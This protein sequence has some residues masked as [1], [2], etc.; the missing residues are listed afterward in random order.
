MSRTVQVSLPSEETD[1]VISK[2]KELKGLIGLRVQRNI[3]LQPKG[4]VVNVDL[5]NSEVNNFLFLLEQEGLLNHKYVSITTSKPT[6]VISES[7]SKKILAESHETSWE[8]M[9]KDLL[10]DSNMNFN[11]QLLML[12]SGF[13]AAVGISMSSVHIVVGAMLIAPGFEPLSRL[14]MGL[15]NKHKDWKNG[16]LDTLKGYFCLV[17]GSAAG[18][19]AVKLLAKD[20]L[21]G[22]SSYLPTGAL[23]EYWTSPTALSLSISVIA[24][25][26]GGVI[27]MSNKSLLTAGV[28]VA[29]A[30]I[31][32]A[33]LIG[34]ALVEGDFQLATESCLRLLLEMAI[35]V[36]FTGI[37]FVWKRLTTQNRS[38]KV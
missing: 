7:A 20:V 13:L 4:D 14:V 11:T 33:A 25:L 16:G 18:A 2:V 29:L 1:K 34:M 30:L 17:A 8:D 32:S 38:M 19:L 27:I 36:F 12:F 24:S 28:M 31:P 37:I 21:P 3:S 15:V 6:S 26:A 5:I 10:H 35:V 9:L 22:S 23:P